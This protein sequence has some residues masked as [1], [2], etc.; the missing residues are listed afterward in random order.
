MRI[1]VI[2]GEGRTLVFPCIWVDSVVE[3][4][5]NQ[6]Q[7]AG[8]G[9]TRKRIGLGY[10]WEWVLPVELLKLLRERFEL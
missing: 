10:R 6:Q 8:G 2:Q 9:L 3:R 1:C 4:L 5:T 7:V